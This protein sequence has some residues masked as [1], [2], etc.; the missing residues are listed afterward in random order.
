MT[1]PPHPTTKEPSSGGEVRAL[2][3]VS[4]KRGAPSVDGDVEKVVSIEVNGDEADEEEW[5]RHPEHPRNWSPRRKWMAVAV[6]RVQHSS[7][8][9]T[10]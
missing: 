6:V 5:K 1:S 7:T 3:G 8:Y 2:S 4:V 9:S 10:F